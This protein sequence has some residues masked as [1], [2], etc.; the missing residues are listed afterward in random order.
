MHIDVPMTFTIDTVLTIIAFFGAIMWQ[1]LSL[2][3]NMEIISGKFEDMDVEIKKITV[4]LVQQEGLT[5]QIN[6]IYDRLDRLELT[7]SRRKTQRRS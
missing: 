7:N 4:L 6:A 2:K 1:T 5:Q 3:K